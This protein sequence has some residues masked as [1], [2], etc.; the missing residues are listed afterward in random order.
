MK[1]LNKKI[2][3]LIQE[4]IQPLFDSQVV[5]LEIL[6]KLEKSYDKF[7]FFGF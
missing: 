2:E 7:N 1:A 6:K 3:L 4:Q 5:P